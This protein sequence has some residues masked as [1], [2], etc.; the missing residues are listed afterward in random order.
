MEKKGF[1]DHIISVISE[2]LTLIFI[3]VI[4]I[5]FISDFKKCKISISNRIKE[6]A[7]L[8]YR[9]KFHFDLFLSNS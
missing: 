4:I 7:P 8:G 1:E 5:T 2:W 9:S 6:T 3:T